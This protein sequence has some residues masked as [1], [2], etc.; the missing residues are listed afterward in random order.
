VHGDDLYV[1]GNRRDDGEIQRELQ[2]Q[3]IKLRFLNRQIVANAVAVLAAARFVIG[4]A[5][6]VAAIVV[7]T[8]FVGALNNGVLVTTRFIMRLMPAATE[9]RMHQQRDGYQ[10]GENGTHVRVVVAQDEKPTIQLLLFSSDSRPGSIEIGEF[11]AP[12]N[13]PVSGHSG[14]HYPHR[15]VKYCV[16]S[17]KYIGY[18]DLAAPPR[19]GTLSAR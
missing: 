1:A 13:P 8:T 12:K 19:P 18:N 6:L 7:M 14:D 15:C 4:L 5:V 2:L 17:S 11:P 10:A 16:P 9:R 3:I